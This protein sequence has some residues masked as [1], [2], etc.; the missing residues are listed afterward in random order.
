[1]RHWRLSSFGTNLASEAGKVQC[2][3]WDA[4]PRI[5]WQAP[6]CPER[7]VSGRYLSSPKTW[8]LKTLVQTALKTL[9]SAPGFGA[10]AALGA[11]LKTP[12]I[13]SGRGA[14]RAVQKSKLPAQ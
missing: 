2:C 8:P 14:R 4:L 5:M 6:I 9:M 1:M 3:H 12:V 11:T 13:A 10:A 7:E